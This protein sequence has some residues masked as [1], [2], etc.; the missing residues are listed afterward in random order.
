M[1]GSLKGKGKGKGKACG[2]VI[3]EMYDWRCSVAECAR[4][5]QSVKFEGGFEGERRGWACYK[6]DLRISLSVF[7]S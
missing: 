6:F 3:E 4:E 1:K 7:A 2:P 5:H